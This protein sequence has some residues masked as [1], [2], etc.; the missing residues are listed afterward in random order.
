[1]TICIKE[2][3]MDLRMLVSFTLYCH[4]SQLSISVKIICQILTNPAG[5][6]YHNRTYSMPLSWLS[7]LVIGC[8]RYVICR[9]YLWV[10]LRPCT[11]QGVMAR[12]IYWMIVK[13]QFRNLTSIFLTGHCALQSLINFILLVRISPDPKNSTERQERSTSHCNPSLWRFLMGIGSVE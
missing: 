12:S 5:K 2:I 11:V 9:A 1:M 6:S 8:E 10:Y 4:N 3:L 13:Y 7:D